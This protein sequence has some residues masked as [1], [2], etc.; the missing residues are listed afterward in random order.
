MVT[1][2]GRQVREHRLVMSNYLGRPLMS[3]EEVHHKNGVRSDNR[4]ENLELWVKKQPCGQKEEDKLQHARTVLK[5][6]C[7]SVFPASEPVSKSTNTELTFSND[8]RSLVPERTWDLLKRHCNLTTN[9]LLSYLKISKRQLLEI[10]R[11]Y[12][13]TFQQLP[14]TGGPGPPKAKKTETF[15]SMVYMLVRTS[16]HTEKFMPVKQLTYKD[17]PPAR[18]VRAAARASLE[19]KAAINASLTDEHRSKHLKR[20]NKIRKWVSGELPVVDQ[21]E[22]ARAAKKEETKAARAAKKEKKAP[23]DHRVIVN[24]E[25]TMEENN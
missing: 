9:E 20:L 6:Y 22:E 23:K 12:P 18:R 15:C 4:L 16:Q 1:L 5:T 11:G 13:K 21:K 7:K 2:N 17:I 25:L 14:L 3:N 8:S 24:E 10:L 19:L